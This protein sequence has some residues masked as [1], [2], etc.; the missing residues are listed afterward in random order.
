MTLDKNEMLLEFAVNIVAGYVHGN[1]L[2]AA[3]LP[4]LIKSTY[5]ALQSTLLGAQ[6]QPETAPL[7]PKVSIKKS[8]TDDYIIC[9][10]DGKKFK[11]LKRHLQ[12]AYGLSPDEYRK[13]WGLA[14]DYPMVAPAYASA[15]SNLA[16]SL[17]L[18][19]KSV[20]AEVPQAV[21]PVVAAPAPVVDVPPPAKRGRPAKAVSNGAALQ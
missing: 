2:P 17:G 10:E 5:G 9:L 4:G 14:K 3:D 13:K 18:G 12:S 6:P 21:A 16:K 19:R 7:V 1:A 15:R 8:I 20:L 11:S